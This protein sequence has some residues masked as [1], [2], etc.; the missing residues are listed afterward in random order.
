MTEPLLFSGI[1]WLAILRGLQITFLLTIL[2]MAFGFVLGTAL[3]LMRVYGSA[4][5]S[6]LAA[7]YVFVFR[8]IP[9]L[10]L[11][12]FLY[13]GAP[14]LTILRVTPLWTFVFSSAFATS[15]LAFS[16]SNAAYL[17]EAIRGG[18]LTVKKGQVEAGFAIGLTT[19]KVISRI[20]L[21]I[22]MRNCLSQIGNETIFTIKA[23]AIASVVT[24]RDLL[25]QAQYVANIYSDNITPLLA[26]AVVYVVLVQ[27]VEGLT[28]WAGK[29]LTISPDQRTKTKNPNLFQPVH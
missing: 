14:Q 12:Y 19:R 27:I 18:I 1:L 9:L 11:L 13:Y 21:P 26:A 15:V 25:G 29:A 17:A 2:S 4:V 16:L 22:A 3:A 6:Y 20:T 8:G 5:T 23:S 28:R 10:I 7:T 24:V